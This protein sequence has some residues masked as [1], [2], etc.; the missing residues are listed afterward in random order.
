[1]LHQ[2]GNTEL[3]GYIIAHPSLRGN[4]RV[5]NSE[6]QEGDNYDCWYIHDLSIHPRIQGKGMTALF[7]SRVENQA[8]TLNY[9][10]ISLVAVNSKTQAF[11][12]RR[13]YSSI[14]QASY[15]TYME[16]N[17]KGKL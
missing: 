6:Q 16:K 4:A 15:G 1:V 3:L 5:L 10:V 2:H 12:R 14:K 8:I 13:G 17:L 7:L 9:D 11:W